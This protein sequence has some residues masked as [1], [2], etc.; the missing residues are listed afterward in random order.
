M[1]SKERVRKSYIKPQVNKVKLEIEEAVLQA[2]K[3]GA[4]LVGKT[5]KNCDHSQCKAG[6]YGS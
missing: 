2:C 6:I 3:R 4:G 5:N 1:M